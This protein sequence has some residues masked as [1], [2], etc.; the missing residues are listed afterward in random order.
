VIINPT[1]QDALEGMEG[2]TTP[3]PVPDRGGG[4]RDEKDGALSGGK[5]RI[6]REYVRKRKGQNAAR[7]ETEGGTTIGFSRNGKKRVG[8]NKIDHATG[9]AAIQ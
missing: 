1:G 5:P 2:G 3:G 7:K 8:T 6:R 4:G 9:R